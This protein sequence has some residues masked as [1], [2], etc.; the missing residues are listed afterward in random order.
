MKLRFFTRL[1]FFLVIA[2]SCSPKVTSTIGTPGA[3]ATPFNHP[4]WSNATNIYEVN[5]RQFSEEGTFDAFAEALP[6]LKS[7]GVEILWFMP[8]TPIGVIDR[9]DSETDLGSYYAVRNYKEVNPEFGT[10][11][12][13]K[14][15]V[16]KAQSMGFKVIT[17]WVANHTAPDN[18]WMTNHPLFYQRDS[19]GEVAVPY[20]WT[21]TRQLDYSNPVLRDSMI[22]A[23]EFW[24]RETNIDGF[25]CDV[26]HLVP[27]DFWKECIDRL[28]MIKDVFMLAEGETP[29]LH[30]AGFDAT[31]TW[32]LMRPMADVYTQAHDLNY[33]DSILNHNIAVYPKNAMRLF[34]TTNHDE[35]SWNG[36]E[37]EKYGDAYK[38]FA[39]FTNTMYQ[40]IPLIY[41]G[42]EIPNRERLKFFVKDP[43]QWTGLEMEPF[44]STLLHL[45]KRNAA[46]DADAGYQRIAT[47]N[48]NA[49]FAYLR[50]KGKKQ[51]LTILN[52][53]PQPQSF[54]IND[55]LIYGKV[56]D[57]F[58]GSSDELHEN[59]LYA[60]EP[61]AFKVL[62]Y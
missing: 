40:S 24:L 2:G 32:S 33:F 48:D 39:V 19:T 21:D 14:N 20:D 51:V 53:S 11:D 55:A 6:R 10:M 18:P 23:M 8:I 29:E 12:D 43:I 60:L 27:A 41:N 57:V 42:Q 3:E 38:A 4:K 35:N 7:M 26:A 28:K 16:K 22:A 59:T 30:H 36:T 25:R 62:E 47:A 1:F 52:L 44:Y 58:T 13:F 45:R 17:D 31:Y 34:F 50:Q 61:W 9:K 46:L 49:I 5:V 15:L 54:T 37:F 56:T